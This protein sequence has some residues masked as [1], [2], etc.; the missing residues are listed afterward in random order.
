MTKLTATMSWQADTN[1][2]EFDVGVLVD[3]GVQS[4]ES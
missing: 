4:N 3:V 1:N 2:T